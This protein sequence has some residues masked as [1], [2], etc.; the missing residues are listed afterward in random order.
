MAFSGILQGREAVSPR[1]SVGSRAVQ[2]APMFRSV[3]QA[4][5]TLYDVLTASGAVILNY[6][7]PT[8]LSTVTDKKS[9][10]DRVAEAAWVS[11]VVVGTLNEAQRAW[12]A[13]SYDGAGT[14]RTQ[15]IEILVAASRAVH[16]NAALVRALVIRN[17]DHGESYCLSPSKIARDTGVSQATAWRADQRMMGMMEGLGAQTI[18][19]LSRAFESKGWLA[20]SCGE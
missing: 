5:R 13:C 1:V 19:A 10:Y 16:K 17:F 20:E 8:V 2:D 14:Q 18:A 15:A 6:D 12:V 3:D 9:R 7:I 4:L 11:R